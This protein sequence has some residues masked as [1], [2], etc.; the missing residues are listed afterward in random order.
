MYVSPDNLIVLYH[1][2]KNNDAARIQHLMSQ[3]EA[4][5]ETC[6]TPD[7]SNLYS[8]YFFRINEEVG[9]C[10]EDTSA[11]RITAQKFDIADNI[12]FGDNCDP[13]ELLTVQQV[14]T[15]M[16][17]IKKWYGPVKN[18]EKPLREKALRIR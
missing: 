9:L 2:L 8:N 6:S 14:Y 3:F 4:D 15:L 7:R 10:V 12:Y 18:S 13:V 11:T 17:Y 1:A 5:E 16:P